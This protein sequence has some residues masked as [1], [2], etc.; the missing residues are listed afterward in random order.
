MN[1]HTL[2]YAGVDT[3]V[4]GISSSRPNPLS[5]LTTFELSYLSP[6]LTCCISKPKNVSL[7]RIMP[8]HQKQFFFLK[9]STQIEHSCHF[10]REGRMQVGERRRV[11]QELVRKASPLFKVGS[12]QLSKMMDAYSHEIT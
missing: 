9:K 3:G 11:R 10:A 8:L 2:T 6:T 1:L 12:G 5:T 7:A 4:D